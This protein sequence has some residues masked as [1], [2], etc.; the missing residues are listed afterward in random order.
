MARFEPETV[1][2]SAF[3]DPESDSDSVAVD[4]GLGLFSTALMASS[5]CN[6][7]NCSCS[8]TAASRASWFELTERGSERVFFLQWGP[9]SSW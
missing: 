9:N 6:C 7:V 5:D 2:V 1:R 8:F 4:V 3:G